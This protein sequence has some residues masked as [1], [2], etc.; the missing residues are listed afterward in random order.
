MQ[1]AGYLI[2]TKSGVKGEPGIFFDYILGA[3]G[4]YIHAKNPLLDACI[5]IAPAEIR[6]LA[7]VKEEVYL[8][9]NKILRSLYELSE[10]LF[11]MAAP[12]EAFA[13][14]VW[15]DNEYHLVYPDQENSEGGVKYSRP[16]NTILDI[17][18]H[19]EMPAFFSGTDTKDEQGFNLSLVIGKVETKP[20]YQLRLCCY[21]YFKTLEFESVFTDV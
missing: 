12:K 2:V 19:G 18:S 9:H 13:A 17:H 1:G 8:I 20:E 6:G 10:D 5:C 11:F 3:D 21:G 15:K 16:P 7:I 14:I 4:L